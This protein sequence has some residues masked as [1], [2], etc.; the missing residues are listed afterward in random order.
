MEILQIDPKLCT[1]WEVISF[2]PSEEIDESIPS[3]KV[4][5]S[6]KEIPLTAYHELVSQLFSQKLV[7]VDFSIVIQNLSFRNN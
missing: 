6:C 7:A 5:C 1:K 3:T 2:R 4:N